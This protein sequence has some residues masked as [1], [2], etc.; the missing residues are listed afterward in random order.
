MH[1]TD[2]DVGDGDGDQ[3]LFSY[4]LYNNNISFSIAFAFGREC[5][6]VCSVRQHAQPAG[7]GATQLHRVH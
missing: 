2:D 7:Q 1:D 6:P 3:G 4:A 5:M